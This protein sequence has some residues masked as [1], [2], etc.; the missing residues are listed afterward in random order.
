[1]TRLEPDYIIQTTTAIQ[2]GVSKKEI[3]Q[4]VEELTGFDYHDVYDYWVPDEY[5]CLSKSRT[6]GYLSGIG[7]PNATDYRLRTKIDW[8]DIDKTYED[9]KR[10]E[11]SLKQPF[12]GLTEFS[13]ELL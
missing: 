9:K 1:M 8:Y 11:R 10:R 13:E 12:N 6:G 4:K 3:I 2:N 5:P 7:N